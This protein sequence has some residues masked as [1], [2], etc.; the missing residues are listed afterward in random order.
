MVAWVKR[1]PKK[2]NKTQNLAFS[3]FI[4]NLKN[5]FKVINKGKS[6]TNAFPFF[7]TK[8]KTKTENKK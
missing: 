1:K 8:L 5:C 3:I 4:K 6:L 7:L 2:K